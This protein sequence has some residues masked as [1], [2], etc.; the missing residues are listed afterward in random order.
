MKTIEVNEKNWSQFCQ[1]I[2]NY[3]RGARVTVELD[4]GSGP[5]TTVIEDAALRHLSFDEHADPCNAN[6]VI[7]VGDQDSKP[8]R[9]VVVEPIRILLRNGK[10]TER[11]NSIQVLAENGTTTMELRPGL[12]QALLKGLEL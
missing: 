8:I 10:D 5:R 3:C 12:E 7:E 4:P 2:E 11:Y 1:S 6:L 9:H